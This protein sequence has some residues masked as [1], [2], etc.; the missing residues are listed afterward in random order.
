MKITHRDGRR[1]KIYGTRRA[2]FADVI[3]YYIIWNDRTDGWYTAD[4][5]SIYV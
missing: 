1:G 3:E 2:S 4:Q 5:L